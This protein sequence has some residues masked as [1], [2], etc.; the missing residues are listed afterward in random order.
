MIDPVSAASLA[1]QL[2][3]ICV[4]AVRQIK[5]A[6]EGMKRVREDLLELLNRTERMR[7]ILELLR[8]LLRELGNTPHKD[9]AIGLNGSA[10][11]QTMRDL[12]SLADK[13][14]GTKISSSLLAGAQWLSLRSKAKELVEKLRSQEADIV[15]ILVI[16]GVAASIKTENQVHELKDKAMSEAEAVDPFDGLTLVDNSFQ[17]PAQEQNQFEP[18][19]TWLGH[20]VQEGHSEH[21][22]SSREELSNAAYWGNWKAIWSILEM[23]QKE[24]AE[25]WINA[26]R[27]KPLEMADKM[28]YWTPLHQAVYNHM[29]NATI[30]LVELLI[31][32]GAFRT[33]RTA[34]TDEFSYK[35]MTPL[36]LAQD[37]G[38]QSL[39]N[40]LSPIIRQAVPAQTLGVLQHKFHELIR[41]DLRDRVEIEH[42]YL[43]V[44][45]VL[46]ELEVPQMWFPVKFHKYS[47]AGYVY[48]LDGRELVVRSY[49]IK[50]SDATQTYRITQ[51]KTLIIDEALVFG[52]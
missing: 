50:A 48:R 30:E 4:T 17:A 21:Y 5:S 46:T 51:E 2:T 24:Y 32:A 19:R 49:N 39:Y 18:L 23:G 44:L 26:T 41:N 20:V 9:M 16:I 40:V 33:L 42:I 47:P 35:D 25:S 6:I 7:H 37:L 8:N 29:N 11:R 43:P 31:K 36:E 38:Y 3:V 45:V 15:N 14:A 13:I 10:C 28:S 34:W 12:E 22:L 27:L 1:V 52:S